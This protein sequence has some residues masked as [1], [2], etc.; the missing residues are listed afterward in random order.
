MRSLQS[1]LLISPP[2]INRKKPESIPA[3]LLLFYLPALSLIIGTM[4]T[5]DLIIR[6]TKVLMPGSTEMA[7]IAVMPETTAPHRCIFAAA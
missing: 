1:D 2:I 7:E 4:D 5:P 6:S 3:F